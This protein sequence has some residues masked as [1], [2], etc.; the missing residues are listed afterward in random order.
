[1]R[2]LTRLSSLT[3]A[4]L[5]GAG[6]TYL[7]PVKLDATPADLEVLVGEWRGEYESQALGRSG[8]IE[9][10]LLA[11]EAEAHGNVLMI[12]KGASQPYGP[13][14]GSDPSDQQPD[15]FRS[16]ALTIRFVRS[17]GGSISGDLDPYWDPDSNCLAHSMFRGRLEVGKMEGT[18]ITHLECNGAE[19]TG[20]WKMTRRPVKRVQATSN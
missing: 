19:A 4:T 10:K 20:T 18:F 6:C 12:P 16:R 9:F 3:L 11:G 8:S 1:M 5:L 15:P 2:M 17:Y 14:Y 7:S 13:S